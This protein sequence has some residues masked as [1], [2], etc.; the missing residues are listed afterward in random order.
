MKKLLKTTLCALA[1]LP[2][3]AWAEDVENNATAFW[4]FNQYGHGETVV[5][6]TNSA[7]Q[8]LDFDGLYAV[9]TA[10]SNNTRTITTVMAKLS[11]GIKDGEAVIFPSGMYTGLKFTEGRGTGCDQAA[12][13]ASKGNRVSICVTKPGKLYVLCR[14]ENA[15]S[16]YSIDVY[17][18]NSSTVKASVPNYEGT[19]FQMITCD[20]SSLSAKTRF[21]IT[22]KSGKA[23]TI[24]GVKYVPSTAANLTKNITLS[25]IGYAT[26]CGPN[27]YTI[28]SGTAKVYYA[29]AI[30]DNSIT[31]TQTTN[32]RIPASQGVILVGDANASLTL[33]SAEN[34]EITVSGNLL[35]AN[36]AAYNLKASSLISDGSSTSTYYNYT[37]GKD[38]SSPV[39][40]HSSGNGDLAAN[41]AFLRT[42]VNVEGSS[43]AKLDLVF[44]DNSET[45]G[46]EALDS[47]AT[48]NVQRPMYNLA[49]QK[50]G[51]S[52]KGIV[53]V[54]GKKYLNK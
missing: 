43:S 50:V 24:Y 1:L 35:V 48:F 32:N 6:V 4:T 44:E 30:S 47:E 45:T 33:K 39:F 7:S 54:N 11:N 28:S 2:L 20:L 14:L 26:F 41:K 25:D 15:S 38:G 36:L 51:K 10:G 27:T 21:H 40:K 5:S 3:G 12:S 37:L 42:T 19:G 8:V 53:I 31:L 52:Y 22:G 34:A 13:A 9:A 17:E 16:D 49:G 29:S 46:I 23:F 18:G